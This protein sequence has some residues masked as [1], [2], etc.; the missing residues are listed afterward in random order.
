MRT[1]IGVDL[2]WYGKPSGLASIGLTEGGFCLQRV[3]RLEHSN[4]IL[5]WIESQSG[6]GDSVVAVDAPLIIRNHTGIRPAERE[7]N[8]DFHRFH[9]GCHAANL[10]RPFAPN[11]LSFSRSLA[12]LGFP[13]GAAMMP[14]EAGRF[15]IEVH[16]HAAAV[17][18]FGLSRIVKYKRGRRNQKANE[19]GRL[20]KLMVSRLRFMNPPLRL[21]LPAV[22]C[23]ESLK[24][25][26]DQIDA[27]LCAY[28]AA[29]WWC[30]G[31]QRNHLY[32]TR[33]E[34]YIVVPDRYSSGRSQ[35][36]PRFVARV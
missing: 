30:W 24:P 36:D 20:R 32:G 16:P 6:S 2:G 1:F 22:P 35:M 14:Q 4:E 19:L 25:V 27:V 21:R 28:V 26:E 12:A 29:H 15:Q 8:R 5:H 11:V 17:N 31:N 18:L 13:H 9:A 10:G 3:T 34:G 33:E 7:L 23:G